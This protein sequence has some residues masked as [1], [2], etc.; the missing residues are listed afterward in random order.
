MYQLTLIERIDRIREQLLTLQDATLV[1]QVE[2]CLYQNLNGYE[3]STSSQVDDSK[4]WTPEIINQLEE[5]DKEIDN[6]DYVTGEEVRA[7]MKERSADWQRG[8]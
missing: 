8:V 6:G 3:G 7:Y 5:A 4:Y 1:A 2:A